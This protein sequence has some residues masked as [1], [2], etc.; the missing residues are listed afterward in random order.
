MVHE[1]YSIPRLNQL[2]VWFYCSICMHFRGGNK[3][4]RSIYVESVDSALGIVHDGVIRTRIDTG[5]CCDVIWF[6][7]S[8]ALHP[9][10]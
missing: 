9:E 10:V 4:A 1:C 3:L 6:Y 5:A 2:L 7:L 8:I